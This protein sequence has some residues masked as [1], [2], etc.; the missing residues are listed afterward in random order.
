[1][2]TEIRHNIN[3]INTII[4]CDIAIINIEKIYNKFNFLL[5]LNLI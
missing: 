1:M 3:L 2:N 5:E 4:N